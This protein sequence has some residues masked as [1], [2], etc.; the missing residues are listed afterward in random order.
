MLRP[1]QQE[2]CQAVLNQW[3]EGNHKTLMVLPTGTGKTVVFSKVAEKRVRQGQR[4]LVLAHR[5][6]LL[7]QAEDKIFK[8]TN[9]HCSLE[10]ADETS[11]GS[12]NPITVGSVQT[13]MRKS[14]LK[15]FP[16][17]ILEPSSLTKPTMPLP[18]AIRTSWNIFTMQTFSV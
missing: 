6:E 1:Y 15:D 2:A 10:K 3:Q 4:V 7:K 14:R 13:L 18:K 11:V 9:L 8:F 17:I 12:Q 16:M 5:D